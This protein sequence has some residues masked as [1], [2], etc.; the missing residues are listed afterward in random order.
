MIISEEIKRTDHKIEQDKSQYDLNRQ[1]TQVY[2]RE[3]LVKMNL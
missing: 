1:R 2:R 3:M